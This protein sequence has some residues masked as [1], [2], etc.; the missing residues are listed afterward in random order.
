MTYS[1]LLLYKG[2]G[3]LNLT[4]EESSAEQCIQPKPCPVQ[5]Q[6]FVSTIQRLKEQWN[7][8]AAMASALSMLG[9]VARHFSDWSSPKEQQ[10]T[11][12]LPAPH[13]VAKG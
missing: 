2:E 4:I 6:A 9:V 7:T 1:A 11:W 8:R 10:A 5:S 13:R 3:F 12:P